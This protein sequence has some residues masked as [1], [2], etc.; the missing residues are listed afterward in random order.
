MKNVILLGVV[1]VVLFSVSAGLSLYLNT[2]KPTEEAKTTETPKKAKAPAEPESDRPIVRS[3]TNMG[4][5]DTSKLA[6]QLREQL[7][8]V[9]DREAKLETRQKQ[10]E[11][12]LQDIRAER[13]VLDRLRIQVGAELK[14][15]GE[16]SGDLDKKFAE[17]ETER[18]KLAQG[19][20]DLSRTRT[21]YD[22]DERVNL[23]KMATLYDAMAPENAA[24]IL[25]QLADTGKME[26]AVKVLAQMK[27]SKASRVLSEM[28]D[29]ALAAQLLEKMKGL[30]P[31]PVTLPEG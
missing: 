16:K 24:K 30:K 15:V 13:D 14:L 12:I 19:T 9:R 26:T 7:G 18:K 28:P 23:G 3:A 4:A 11:L 5:D 6:A 2:P 1:A 17:L 20:A 25:Q 31:A 10:V 8:T 27:A 21:E 29:A 22:K